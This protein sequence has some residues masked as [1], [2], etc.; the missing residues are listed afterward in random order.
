MTELRDTVIVGGGQAGLAAG[1]FLAQQGRD[2]VILDAGSAP[3]AA[4]RDR[5]DSLTL[6]T[7][8]RYDSLPGLPFPGDPDRYPHRDE[9]VDYLTRYAARFGLPVELGRRV[10]RVRPAGCGWIVEAGERTICASNVVVATGAFQIPRVP[11]ALAERLG[12]GVQ[13]LHSAAYRR[14]E[15]IQGETVLVVGGGNTGYQIAEELAA[16][17]TVHLAIGTRQLPM[18]QRL[19]G[20]DIFAFLDRLGAMRKT[21]DSRLGRR[22]KGRDTLVG[23]GPRAARRLGIALHGRAVGAT[24]SSVE[25]ADGG[26]VEPDAV[27]WATGF[28]RD[29]GIVDAPVFDEGGEI[30]HERG[31]TTAPGLYFLGLPWMHT[32]GSALLGWVA[33]DAGHIAGHIAQRAASV[34][35]PTIDHE[36]AA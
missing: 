12:P 34:A 14:P 10:E 11:A 24:P 23:Y 36:V 19:A 21:A 1:Y 27:V 7:S 22:M 5:W 16:T 9:V 15:Q 4:W 13:Q 26:R 2:F 6:F 17:R 30:V 32:R 28:E 18:P 31:V 8:A 29:H 3:A 35:A 33:D 25:F 20:R